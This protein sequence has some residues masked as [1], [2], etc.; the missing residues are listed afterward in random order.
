MA[1]NKINPFPTTGYIGKEYFC[2]RETELTTLKNLVENGVNTTLISPRRLGKS[3]LI[4]RL[5]E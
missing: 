4:H 2:D 1:V 3:A 5:F